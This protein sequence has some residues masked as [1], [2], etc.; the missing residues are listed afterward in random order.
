V[1]RKKSQLGDRRLDLYEPT[2]D[3]IADIARLP[4]RDESWDTVLIDPPHNSRMQWNHD[5]LS[6]LARVARIRI[7]FQ[8]WFL[9]ANKNGKFKKAHK[10]KLVEVAVWQPRT[11]FGR[12]NVISIFDKA[13]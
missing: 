7:I 6:E 12:A 3:V 5:M 11:Y 8:H 9:P 2:A 1:L 4:F 10:F 13:E